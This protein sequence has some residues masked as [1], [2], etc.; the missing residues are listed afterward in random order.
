MNNETLLLSANIQC[1]CCWGGSIQFEHS[2]SG[3]WCTREQPSAKLVAALNTSFGNKQRRSLSKLE[4]N[5]FE[6]FFDCARVQAKKP[7][8]FRNESLKEAALGNSESGTTGTVKWSWGQN[9]LESRRKIVA[10]FCRHSFFLDGNNCN[11]Q[12]GF[13]PCCCYDPSRCRR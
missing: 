3:R 4:A 9:D 5:V 10:G 11:A 7:K 6:S 8:H 13:V 1:I 2:K 12:Q